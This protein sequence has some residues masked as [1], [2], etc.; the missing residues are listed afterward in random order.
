MLQR[1]INSNY[2]LNRLKIKDNSYCEL[3]SD[4]KIH[5][6]VHAFVDCKWTC[7][8]MEVLLADLDPNREIFGR[9]D[10]RKW[11]FGV[12]DVTVNLLI[13]L[14]KMYL[15]QVRS[16]TKH[17][18]VKTLRKQIYYRILTDKKVMTESKFKVKWS[19]YDRLFKESEQYE[20]SFTQSVS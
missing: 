2:N 15:C 9:L 12:N 13:L 4:K 20:K 7:N 6:T 10:W 11:I 8:K 3:C 18:S 17:L 1:L 5:D 19:K 14:I 16:S